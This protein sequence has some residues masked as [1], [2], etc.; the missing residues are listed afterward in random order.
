MIF[1]KNKKNIN[2]AHIDSE[3]FLLGCIAFPLWGIYWIAT[4]FNWQDLL[5]LH[6]AVLLG[7]LHTS[8][9]CHRGWSH[10]AWKPGRLLTIY[11]LFVH[12]V[13]MFTTS[14]GWCAVHRKHHRFED[15]AQDPHSPYFIPR[16]R[17]LLYPR[18]MTAGPEY[19][20]DLT[21]DKDH[22]FFY[23]YYYQLNIAWWV[24]LY[25]ID[26]SILSFWIAYLGG[27]GLKQR[28]TN[29]VGHADMVNKG[30]SNRISWGY[31]FL[32]GE[33]WH[34]NHHDNPTNWRFGHR[35]YEVDLGGYCIWFFDKVGLGKI[36]QQSWQSQ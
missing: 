2:R 16:W 27:Y 5:W 6:T 9:F 1:F 17:V 28:S 12:T 7:G 34:K 13:G 35:W 4:H 8:L 11:G 30:A 14:I 36:R 29:T 21:K 25:L 23:K 20:K 19:V 3:V 31:L 33:P 32:S 18:G 15:T 10:R 26:P 24:V 22:I